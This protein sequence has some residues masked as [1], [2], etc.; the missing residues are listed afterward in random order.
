MCS[1]VIDFSFSVI[2]VLFDLAHNRLSFW[3]FFVEEDQVFFFSILHYQVIY[4]ENFYIL[5]VE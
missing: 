1:C 2:C 4:S 3:S 5:Q